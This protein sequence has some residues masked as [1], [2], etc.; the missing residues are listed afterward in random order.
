MT[1]TAQQIDNAL[2]CEVARSRQLAL[3]LDLDGTLVPFA[4]TAEEAVLDAEA[5]SLLDALHEIG[6]QVVIVTGRTMALVNTMRPLV[7]HAWWAA[8]HGAWRN[9]GPAWEGPSPA[10]ELDRLRDALDRLPAI[11]GIRLEPKSLSVCVHWR[12]V[13]P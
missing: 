6:V 12:E 9:A 13:A 1:D 4:R 10:V 8:E 2:W 3:L 5:V 11:P 7:R